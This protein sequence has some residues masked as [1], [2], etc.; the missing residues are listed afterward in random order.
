MFW[1]ELVLP[2]KWEHRREKGE[3]DKEK[4]L[5]CATISAAYLSPGTGSLQVFT[6]TMSFSNSVPA[7]GCPVL[8]QEF[9]HKFVVVL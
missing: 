5:K 8:N 2:G 7:V 4:T 6:L 3:R 9:G 1:A